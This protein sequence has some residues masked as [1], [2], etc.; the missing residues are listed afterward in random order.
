MYLVILENL[1][2]IPNNASNNSRFRSLL[3]IF[4]ENEMKIAI[5]KRFYNVDVT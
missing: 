5:G 3:S 4:L 2:Y 1:V